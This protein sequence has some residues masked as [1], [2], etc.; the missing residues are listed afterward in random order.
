MITHIFHSTVVSGPETLALPALR[1]LGQPVSIVFLDE[2]RVPG[3]ADAPVAYARSL[4]HDVHTVPVQG[5]WDR[6]AFGALAETLARLGTT[7]AHAH[8]VKASLYLDQAAR[9]MPVR[10]KLV[11]THHGAAARKGL[12]RVYEELYVRWTLPRFDAVLSV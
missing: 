1:K 10:P 8:D 4:G 7:L 9:R 5:R 12:I 11:S 2:K 6:S 3:G